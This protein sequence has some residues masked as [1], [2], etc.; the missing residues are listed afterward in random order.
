VALRRKRAVV[1]IYGQ[2]QKWTCLGAPK[3]WMRVI[4]VLMITY[5]VP[6]RNHSL[7]GR[8]LYVPL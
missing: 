4:G 6:G 3:H 2:L 7:T 5:Q 8:P 1:V